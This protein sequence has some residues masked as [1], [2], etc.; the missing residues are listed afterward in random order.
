MLCREAFLLALFRKLWCCDRER[1]LSLTTVTA[2]QEALPR[3]DF[4]HLKVV[5]RKPDEGQD[6]MLV[7]SQR[8]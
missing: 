8:Q 1:S 2:D 4:F 7:N 5:A 3:A 6:P